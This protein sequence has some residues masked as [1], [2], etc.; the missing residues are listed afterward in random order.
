MD[1]SFNPFLGVRHQ[2]LAGSG[3]DYLLW[4]SELEVSEE[5]RLA[6]FLRY[7]EARG[8]ERNL[9]AALR[10]YFPDVLNILP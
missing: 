3:Q 7:R 1:L 5:H 6:I 2:V 4:G 9:G 8:G 10:V